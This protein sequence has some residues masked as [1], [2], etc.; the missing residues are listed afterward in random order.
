MAS[1]AWIPCGLRSLLQSS[2]AK[3]PALPLT[4]TLT[5]AGQVCASG[6][7]WWSRSYR[8]FTMP[9]KMWS[10]AGVACSNTSM[11]E[12]LGMGARTQLSYLLA[13]ARKPECY[14]HFWTRHIALEYCPESGALLVPNFHLSS[15][16]CCKDGRVG[17][18]NGLKAKENV[19]RHFTSSSGTLPREA[20]CFLLP[21]SHLSHCSLEHGG[22][23]HQLELPQDVL[24]PRNYYRSWGFLSHHK[25]SRK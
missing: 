13:L 18:G 5:D 2:P 17:R 12:P 25:C 19:C 9:R 11:A 21:L 16:D 14:Q 6:Q 23:L 1:R 10:W 22:G 3:P 7:S 15:V 4:V 24:W 8:V 20:W